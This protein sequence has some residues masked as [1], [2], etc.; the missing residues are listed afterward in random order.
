MGENPHHNNSIKANQTKYWS[1]SDTMQLWHRNMTDPKTYDILKQYGWDKTAIT[2]QYNSH[3]FRC[4]EFDSTPAYLAL[5]CSFTE[6]VGLPIE[7][8]WP[9]ILSDKL[10]QPVLNLGVGGSS[11]DT[12]FRLLNYYLDKLNIIGVFILEPSADRFELFELGKPMTIM[13]AV[14]YNKH[15]ELIRQFWVTGEQ[16][17]YYNV[18]KNRLAIQMLCKNLKLVSFSSDILISARST[19]MARDLMHFGYPNH[20]YAANEFFCNLISQDK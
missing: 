18:L 19:S 7:Q 17:T 20:Q 2:Y 15:K 16:N 6:G 11:L 13:P 10:Q 3:G 12:C 1:G 8:T 9:A 5:G 4:V 14:D